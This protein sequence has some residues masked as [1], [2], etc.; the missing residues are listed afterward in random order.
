MFLAQRIGIFSIVAKSQN[1][2][3]TEH[4]KLDLQHKNFIFNQ[5][6]KHGENKSKNKIDVK[7]WD[8]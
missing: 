8:V 2:N 5:V 6:F 4:R 3:S 7:P 1:I